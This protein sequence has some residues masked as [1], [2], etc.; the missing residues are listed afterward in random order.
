MRGNVEHA[1]QTKRQRSPPGA[2][3]DNSIGFQLASSLKDLRVR[4]GLFGV[5]A[6]CADR[7]AATT[8][9]VVPQLYVRSG[10]TEFENSHSCSP[11]PR[12]NP[13]TLYR[14]DRACVP[15]LS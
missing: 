10:V 1:R 15:R 6:V 12:L 13:S 14:M 5:L 11:V 3:S 8:Q 7:K 2:R 4:L 9:E